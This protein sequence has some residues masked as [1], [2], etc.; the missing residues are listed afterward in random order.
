M[1]P[2]TRLMSPL[3]SVAIALVLAV[4]D[5]PTVL[6]YLLTV[7]QRVLEP[8]VQVINKSAINNLI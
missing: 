8:V 2:P 7:K 4:V 3:P 1:E 5:V 6:L